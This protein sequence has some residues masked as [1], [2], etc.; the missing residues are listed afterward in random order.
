[1]FS[2]RQLIVAVAL[3]GLPLAGCSDSGEAAGAGKSPED[4]IATAKT[5]L[6]ETTG[7]D[8]DLVTHN[9]PDDVSGISGAE[10]VA[11]NAPAFEG[12]LTVV[13][14]GKSFGV[15]VVA[16][17]GKTYAQLP[18]VPVWSDVDPGE[19]GAPEP[20]DL[21]SPDKGF[22]AML[23]ATTDLEAGESVRGGKDNDEIL[24]EYTGTVPSEAMSAIIPSVPEGNFEATYQIA[25]NGEL[26]QADLTGIFYDGSPEMTYTVTFQNYGTTKEITAP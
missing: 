10:G 25:D 6:D 2:S 8:L 24:T 4:V 21:V 5:T 18:L 11:T 26:R 16:V 17:D 22:S 3:L 1:M 7:L 19:Y 9:L 14:S 12:E 23:A 15:P 13:L 20:A